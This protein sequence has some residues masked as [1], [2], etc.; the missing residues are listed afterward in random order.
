MSTLTAE[1][2]RKLAT[3][4][5]KESNGVSVKI[6]ETNG[7]PVLHLVNRNMPSKFA[8]RDLVSEA[9][10]DEHPWNRY[11]SQPRSQKERRPIEGV[12]EAVANKEAQ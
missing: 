4:V 10:W 2:A 1:S 11:N 5:A 6:G 12:A 7:K 8:A 9:D 3:R